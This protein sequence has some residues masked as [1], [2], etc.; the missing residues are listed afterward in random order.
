VLEG[1]DFVG[2]EQDPHHC[3]IARARVEH[4]RKVAQAEARRFQ[5]SLFS[6]N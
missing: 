2:I 6:E 3:E 1:R 5:A 4:W